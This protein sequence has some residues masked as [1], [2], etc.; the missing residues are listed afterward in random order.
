VREKAGKAVYWYQQRTSFLPPDTRTQRSQRH[1]TTQYRFLAFFWVPYF[2][3]CEPY[4]LP[5]RTIMKLRRTFEDHNCA[6]PGNSESDQNRKD[7]SGKSNSTDIQHPSETTCDGL[8]EDSKLLEFCEEMIK[9]FKP[10]Y[11]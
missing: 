5:R 10:K 9:H 11:R 2:Y 7:L 4:A 3:D 8:F 1:E 6:F